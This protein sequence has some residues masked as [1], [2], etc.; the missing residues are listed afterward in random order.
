[1]RMVEA[2]VCDPDEI[3]YRRRKT[4]GLGWLTHIEVERQNEEDTKCALGW[5]R[6][7]DIQAA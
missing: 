5:R 7:Q 6:I 1:M 4:I 3:M 2:V